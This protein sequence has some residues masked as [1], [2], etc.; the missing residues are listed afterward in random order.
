[1]SMPSG[2]GTAR[3]PIAVVAAVGDGMRGTPGIAAKVF[4][5]AAREL[6]LMRWR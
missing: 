1:M 3:A 6:A 4:A 5:A 2:I